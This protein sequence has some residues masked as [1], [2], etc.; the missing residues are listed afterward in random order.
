[1]SSIKTPKYYDNLM[2]PSD[3]A[4]YI[5]NGD[6]NRINHSFLHVLQNEVEIGKAKSGSPL[7]NM[8]IVTIIN[9]RIDP[10]MPVTDEDLEFANV[11]S[12][13]KTLRDMKDELCKLAAERTIFLSKD[14]EEIYGEVFSFYGEYNFT[15]TYSFDYSI[16]YDEDIRAKMNDIGVGVNMTSPIYSTMT[17]VLQLDPRKPPKQVAIGNEPLI[18]DKGIMDDPDEEYNPKMH[19][20]IFCTCAGFVPFIKRQLDKGFV[21][22]VRMPESYF[23]PYSKFF[24]PAST[25]KPFV[26]KSSIILGGNDIPGSMET[27]GPSGIIF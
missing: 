17:I 25:I 10:H 3:G 19:K 26:T 5:L 2:L 16:L 8:N 23:G 15:H 4:V 1:M 27:K 20:N 9:E 12:S 7:D 11:P 14:N 18:I 13:K 24:I 21:E 22:D 6:V